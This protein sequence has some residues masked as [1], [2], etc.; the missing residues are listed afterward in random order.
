MIV[1][2]PRVVNQRCFFPGGGCF[3]Y[4]STTA[5]FEEFSRVVRLKRRKGVG[6]LD[7]EAATRADPFT[8]PSARRG[9]PVSL[10]A[11][12]ARGPVTRFIT[13]GN[14]HRSGCLSRSAFTGAG[15]C[16]SGFWLLFRSTSPWG[17]RGG[18][19]L[20]YLRSEAKAIPT[21]YF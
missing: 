18:F 20:F 5:Q 2:R 7:H 9:R 3:Q 12:A 1:T 19:D 21:G 8:S 6:V 10:F 17:L 14:M 15:F 11:G 4:Q 13:T 16:S